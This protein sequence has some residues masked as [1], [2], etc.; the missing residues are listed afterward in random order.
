M[1]GFYHDPPPSEQLK[2]I[3]KYQTAPQ[4]RWNH[5]I[6]LLIVLLLLVIVV[7]ATNYHL[8]SK[9]LKAVEAAGAEQGREDGPAGEKSPSKISDKL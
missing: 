9:V 5:F 7:I 6:L 1:E 8:S 4:T 2:K 3:I